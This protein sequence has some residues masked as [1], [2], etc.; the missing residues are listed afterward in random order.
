MIGGILPFLMQWLALS[1]LGNVL[2]NPDPLSLSFSPSHTMHMNYQPKS[3]WALLQEF[4][5]IPEDEIEKF[6]PQIANILLEYE[7]YFT[8]PRLIE[9]YESIIL[10]K[11]ANCLPFGIK[12]SSLLKVSLKLLISILLLSYFCS[13]RRHHKLLVRV[14]CGIYF[15]CLRRH[16]KI[17]RIDCVSFKRKLRLLHHLVPIYHHMRVDFVA[18]TTEIW[19]L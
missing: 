4:V 12:V 14:C 9:Q 13:L 8:D 1:H 5:T 7:N 3:Q 16:L 10:N 19:Y 18:N 6:L 2:L 17:V 15:H 11:C